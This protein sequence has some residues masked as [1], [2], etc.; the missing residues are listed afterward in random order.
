ALDL[1]YREIVITGELWQI[2][3]QWQAQGALL[4]GLSDKPDEAACGT[5]EGDPIHRLV[6][7]VVGT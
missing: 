7:H 3:Q 5:G 6:T 1:L 4:F 2:A